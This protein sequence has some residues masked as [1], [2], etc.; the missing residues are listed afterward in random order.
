MNRLISYKNLWVVVMTS[1]ICSLGVA[2][3]Q[4][5]TS[6]IWQAGYGNYPAGVSWGDIDGDGWLDCVIANG[7]DAAFISNHVYFNNGGAVS[8]TPGWVS[9][10]QVPSDNIALGDLDNDG[11]LDLVVSNLGYSSGGLPPLPQVIYYNNGGLS[12]S[13]DWSSRPA[14]SFSCAIGD[15][16]GDG[17]LDIVFAQGDYF[18]SHLQKTVIYFNNGGTFDTVP[19]WETDNLYYGVEVA[20]VDIDLDGDHDLAL[21][22]RTFGIAIFYNDNGILE[23]TPSWQT[24]EI[25]GGRQMAFGDYD[26]DGYP[27]LA[28][29]GMA[30][31]FFLFKNMGGTLEMTP[32]WQTSSYS[33]PS[34]VAWADA[35]NDGDLDLAAGGWFCPVGV[36]ENVNGVLSD[37]FV[38]SY[39]AG[40]FLLQIAWCDFD[41]DSL[42]DDSEIFIGDGNRQLFYLKQK[43]IHELSA[44]ELNSTPLSLDQY[45]FDPVEAWI[46]LASPSAI[47]DTLAVHY[48]YSVD[49]DLTLTTA[50]RAM[51]FENEYVTGLE[52]GMKIP[53][54]DY[55]AGPTIINGPLLLPPDKDCRIFDVSG[56][57]VSPDNMRPGIYFIELDNNIVQKII[58]IR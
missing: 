24:Y 16:D 12:T 42:I 23:T 49:L 43:P 47:G 25:I 52:E 8:T 21:G 31:D 30:E 57:T 29:A 48:T 26:G 20:F 13:P 7:T 15:P 14:N 34:C 39:S 54:E 35:D 53:V 6:P 32:S 18:T 19:G 10:D 55:Y 3:I 50:S 27:D 38:W 22:A 40:T 11:D 46:S 2:D 4:L 56:R 33:E 58:R 1:A 17:D 28:V 5:S 44:V 37:T 45:C 41:E 51:I 9:D 36:F